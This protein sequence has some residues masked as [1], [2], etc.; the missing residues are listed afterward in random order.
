MAHSFSNYIH[1]MPRLLRVSDECREITIH[2]RQAHVRKVLDSVEDIRVFSVYGPVAGYGGWIE[3]V[4]V[5]DGGRGVFPRRADAR[6]FPHGQKRARSGLQPVFDER[7]VGRTDARDRSGRVGAVCFRL[8][9]A[10]RRSDRQGNR[11]FS[12]Y[13]K[14]D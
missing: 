5:D 1:N 13:H 11:R 10:K 14:D 6:G 3:R 12:E 9:G 2:A 7:A 8:S 4:R